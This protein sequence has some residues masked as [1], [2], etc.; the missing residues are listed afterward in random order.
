M[1]WVRLGKQGTLTK[2]RASD[3][4]RI[5]YTTHRGPPRFAADERAEV[6]TV[7]PSPPPPGP[8]THLS[9]LIARFQRVLPWL[10]MQPHEG[11]GCDDT[12]RWMDQ[13]GPD[14]CED[15]LDQIVDRLEEEATNRE[16]KFPFRRTAAKQMTQWAIRRARKAE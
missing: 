12:A 5:V 8:G 10:D 7:S 2:W 1:M 11:C 6:P 3:G 14:G 9:R 4:S 13:L 16:I 15:N